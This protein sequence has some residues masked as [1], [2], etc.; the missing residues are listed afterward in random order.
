MPAACTT[1]FM[2]ASSYAAGDGTGAPTPNARRRVQCVPVQ[3]SVHDNNPEA[4][5]E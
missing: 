3:F 1:L 5:E 4:S 2:T